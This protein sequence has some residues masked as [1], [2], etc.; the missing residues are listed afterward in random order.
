MKD[1]RSFFYYA[2][3]CIVLLGCKHEQKTII[4]ENLPHYE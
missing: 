4:Y 3:L 2:A 1:T